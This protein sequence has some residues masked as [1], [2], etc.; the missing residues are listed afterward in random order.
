MMENDCE[1]EFFLMRFSNFRRFSTIIGKSCAENLKSG[2]RDGV[3]RQVSLT[4]SNLL[5]NELA[6]SKL[7]SGVK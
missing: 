7:A 6:G 5:L 1:S 4:S 2:S 3:R